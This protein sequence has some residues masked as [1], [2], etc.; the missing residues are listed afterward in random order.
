MARP[1][2]Y[3]T[4]WKDK[5]IVIQG[6]ARDGLNNQQIAHNMGI[7]A[8]TLY[9]WQNK[10]SEFGN[11]LKK[12]KEVVDRQVENALLKRALGYSVEEVTRERMYVR[13]AEGK[14]ILDADGM[15]MSELAITKKVTKHITPDTT[16][17][18]FW[19]KNRK[20]NEWRDKK[21][22]GVTVDKSLEDFFGDAE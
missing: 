12:G 13:N 20:P 18:I 16:A 5:L 9:E 2:L 1:S 8:K 17:Q 22:V 3:E 14:Q 7:S 6:W 15:P 10:Y 11:T 4:K 19:L 21:E